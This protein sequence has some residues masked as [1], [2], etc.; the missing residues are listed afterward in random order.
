MTG[1]NRRRALMGQKMVIHRWPQMLICQ[2][3]KA[4]QIDRNNTGANL[5]K[6]EFSNSTLGYLWPFSH[7]CNL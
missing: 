6:N 5:M 7:L 4:W 3:L 1:R 2:R